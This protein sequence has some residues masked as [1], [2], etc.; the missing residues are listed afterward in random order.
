MKTQYDSLEW[1]HIRM[2]WV[3]VVQYDGTREHWNPAELTGQE[4]TVDG[5]AFKVRGVDMYRHMIS[6]D[7]PYKYPIGLIE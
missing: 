6:P 2:G 5:Y 1:Y 3:A 7:H 4:V